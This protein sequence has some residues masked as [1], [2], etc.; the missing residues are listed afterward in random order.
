MFDEGREFQGR[1]FGTDRVGKVC[2][3][4][5]FHVKYGFP[6]VDEGKKHIAFIPLEAGFVQGP[7]EVI[8]EVFDLVQIVFQSYGQSSGVGFFG[9]ETVEVDLV[10]AFEGETSIVV[11][12]IHVVGFDPIAS[13]LNGHV[14][15]CFH[16]VANRAVSN[17]DPL[18]VGP[19]IH[20]FSEGSRWKALLVG[21]PILPRT[22]GKVT[23]DDSALL[24]ES[25]DG[26]LRAI[27]EIDVV[28]GDIEGGIEG[29]GELP[30]P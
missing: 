3:V 30:L 28:H 8:H 23:N 21:T 11:V 13:F 17:V 5:I 27:E 18:F 14:E 29:P 10:R 1:G 22:C 26:V 16:D 19:A 6:C 25:V 7:I 15:S 12:A 4:T 24:L 20:G 2:V 9:K